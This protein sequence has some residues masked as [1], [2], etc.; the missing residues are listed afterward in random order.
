M[1]LSFAN[2]P[3]SDTDRPWPTFGAEPLRM[4]GESTQYTGQF[5]MVRNITMPNSQSWGD[6]HKP[7][8]MWSI[9]SSIVRVSK[10]GFRF[11]IHRF[12]LTIKRLKIKD[13]V[14]FLFNKFDPL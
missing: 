3:T 14:K 2:D 12:S 10:S 8:L 11:Y 1:V 5:F 6:R 4:L 7:N 13:Y 9:I